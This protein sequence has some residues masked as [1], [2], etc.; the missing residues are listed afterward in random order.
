VSVN[1]ATPRR[2]SASGSPA[3]FSL[4][5]VF[6]AVTAVA[7]FYGAWRWF[8]PPSLWTALPVVLF[9]VACTVA[10]RGDSPDAPLTLIAIA[11]CVTLYEVVDSQT[12]CFASIGPLRPADIRECLF[13]CYGSG[14]ALPLF[15][16]V[17]AL[18]M[19]WKHCRRR[20]SRTA[21]F[22][23]A[24]AVVAFVDVTTSTILVCLIVNSIY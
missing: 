13:A 7:I 16:T 3:Q 11:W 20:P 23:I 9:V 10:R 5:A 4:A 22:V 6:Y 14:I 18:H 19:T 24:C 12:S 2:E 8:G 17:P 15:L 21:V 1:E